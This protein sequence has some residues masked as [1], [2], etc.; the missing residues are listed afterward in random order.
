MDGDFVTREYC[1][2]HMQE[3]EDKMDNHL[4]L[5]DEKIAETAI[6]F[7]AMEETVKSIKGTLNMVLG[8]VV[9]GMVSIIGILLT[10]GI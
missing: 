1:E 6:K 10:R 4:R 8:A 3:I 2:S 5:L 7:A 9:T